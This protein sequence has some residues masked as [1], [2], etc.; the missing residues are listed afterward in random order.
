VQALGRNLLL[1]PSL[2]PP[3]THAIP[4][5]ALVPKALLCLTRATELGNVLL[6]SFDAAHAQVLSVLFFFVGLFCMHIMAA[7]V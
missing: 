4:L 1:P 5:S 2:T 7:S 6:P 3:S